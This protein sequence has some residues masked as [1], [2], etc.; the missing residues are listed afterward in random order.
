MTVYPVNQVINAILKKGYKVFDGLN[1][2]GIRASAKADKVDA[3]DD[4]MYQIYKDIGGE[5]RLLAPPYK[6]TT[7][8]GLSMLLKPMNVKGT[9]ILVPGQ[10]V[11]C[12]A[13]GKHKG[14]YEALV[15]IAP[16]KVYRDNDKDKEFD[17]LPETIENGVI[18]LNSHRANPEVESTVVGGWSAACQV[19]ANPKEFKTYMLNNKA[20][21]PRSGKFS[22]TLLKE[23]EL[24]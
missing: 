9:G 13:I 6:I 10:Y 12:W 1:L 17:M 19:H 8:P 14:Q 24:L 11:D 4:L 16:M 7:Q 2:I 20:Y 22:Y 15:Q 21:Q 23:E 5:C 18:G 3:F